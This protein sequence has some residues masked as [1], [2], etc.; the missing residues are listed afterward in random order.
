MGLKLANNALS[1]LSAGI[2][3]TDVTVVL[4]PGGGAAFP[5]LGAGDYF[6]ATIV[7]ADGTLEIV[8][9]TARATD[10]LTVVRAQENTTAKSFNAG[11][12]LELRLTAG[13]YGAQFSELE[14]RISS[15]NNLHLSGTALTP[16]EQW[17]DVPGIETDNPSLT[18]ELNAQAQ[19]LLNRTEAAVRRAT[20]PIL[21]FDGTNVPDK[22]L[23]IFSDRDTVGD[24]AGGPLRFLKGSTATA[25]GGTVYAVPGGRLVREGW[26][27]FG[28]EARWFGVKADWNGTTG[29]DNTSP[30][31]SALA[32]LVPVRMPPGKC[33]VTDTIRVGTRGAALIGAGARRRYG[34]SYTE[35][36]YDG[37][38]NSL[39][40]VI[41][42]GGNEVGAEP[43]ID[44][45]ANV[46]KNLISNANGK[47][48]FAVYGTYLTNETEVDN[49]T[50]EGAT[51]FNMYFARSWYAS[52]TN[53]TSLAC[54]GKGIAIG[55]P[56]ELQNG[57]NYS[58]SWVTSAPLEMNQ[59]KIDNIRSHESGQY[60]S[61]TNP[62]T[63]TPTSTTHRRQG[64]GIG[65]GLGNGFTM[66][67]IVAEKSGG[68]NLYVY[69]GPQPR[70]SIQFGYLESSALNSGLL[71]ASTLPNIIL[72]NTDVATGI[73]V[74][75]LFCNYNS[76]GIFHT[77]D[78]RGTTWLR[79]LHQPRFL[80]SLDGVIDNT[81]YSYVLKDNVRYEC[82]YYNTLESLMSPAGYGEVN[83][84]YSFTVNVL[85]GGGKKAIYVKYNGTAYYGSYFVNYDDGTS[86]S[87]SFSALTTSYQLERVVNAG[88]K[89]ITKGGGT[90]ATDNVVTFKV[91]NT[92][93]TA[94]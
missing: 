8:K 94:G 84:R 71:A 90:G 22:A 43:S 24:G 11:D 73:E 70:K 64:Y 31:N 15:Q 36:V 10:V 38:V 12:R 53:L 39:K 48:G 2:S 58:A 89:S 34:N 75:D 91:M 50:A 35:I 59:C 67:N 86:A 4:V 80:K 69:S 1:R 41:L 17:D 61:V 29:T 21:S 6:P 14:S 32:K 27:V 33:R 16:V 81:L 62:G 92:P 66:T 47:A 77:G 9:V 40:A 13:T 45:T 23:I 65:A 5:T 60:Y 74:C 72:E 42:I 30:I 44:G 83:T 26:S 85:P 25:D 57:T 78:T 88:V 49:V 3:P 46:V 20:V 56:L 68:V 76:G 18:D 54:R 79:N 37:P 51:E 55:M 63:Y 19:A 52:Y 28:I 82:G 7:K 93:E 87:Y